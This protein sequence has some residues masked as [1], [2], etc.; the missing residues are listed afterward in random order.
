MSLKKFVAN[1]LSEMPNITKWQ[2]KFMINLFFL[3]FSYRGRHN[4][5]NLARQSDYN[6]G[7][8]RNNYSKSFDFL[9]FN[10]LLIGQCCS[11][12]LVI[13]FDP[14]FISKSGK[15]TPGLGY[16]WSGC[17]GLAKKGLE[18]GGFG[19]VDIMN[20]TCMHL[21]CKQTLLNKSSDSP[22]SAAVV[23]VANPTNSNLLAYYADLIFDLRA[24][25]QK[26]SPYLAVDAYFS[27]K[28]FIDKMVEANF[29]VISRF[30]KDVALQYKYVG[31]KKK[32]RGR[33]KAFDGKVDLWNLREEHFTQIIEEEKW[34]A[35]EGVVYANALKRWVKVVVVHYFNE[36]GAIK[37]VRTFFSTDCQMQGTDIIVYYKGRF[38]IEFLYR[39]AKQFVGLEQGQSRKEERI[40]FHF[41]A[42]LTTVSLAKALYYLNVEEQ[43]RK[44]FSMSSVKTRYGNDLLIHK[45]F[46]MFGIDPEH[47]INK[48]RYYEIRDFGAIAA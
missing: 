33:P 17:A 2:R 25:L 24:D 48:E 1:I 28:S 6:E 32:G 47:G 42:A 15:H 35:Y 14:S 31:I 8:I 4:F 11:K 18:I 27:K 21:I 39:D 26:T 43:K 37:K 19:A 38:Q 9:S 44:P 36:K 20:N 41:N 5:E 46:S 34:S 7:T 45:L 10:Q 30:R 29:T 13:A 40:D 16:F 3:L 23:E 22:T 12:E